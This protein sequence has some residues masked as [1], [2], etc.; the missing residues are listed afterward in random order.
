LTTE[1]SETIVFRLR[2]DST[3]G[4]ILATAATVTV[5]DSSQAP[6]PTYSVSPS[7]G[8][9]NE[10][11]NVIYTVTTTNFGYGTLY[12]TNSGTTSSADF[13][14][15]QNSGSVNISNNIGYITRTLSSDALTEGSESII[16]D[17]RT[18]S[19]S[20]TIVATAGT[21]TV[22]DTSLSVAVSLSPL[23][24]AAIDAGA[25]S[26]VNFTATG[27]TGPYSYNVSSG[28]L[29]SGTT[30]LNNGALQ[31][32][33]TTAGTYSFTVTA[34]DSGSPVHTGAR[35]YSWVINPVYNEIL[36]GP[37]SC[38]LSANISYTITGG[39][40]NDAWSYSVN[41]GSIYNV[42]TPLS[43]TGQTTFSDRYFPNPGTYVITVFFNGT[44]HTRT[45]TT[46]AANPTI[47]ISP[48]SDSGTS[49]TPY[50][51]QFTASGGQGPYTWALASGSLPAGVSYNPIT[52]L[53][54]GTPTTPG[55]YNFQMTAIDAGDPSV[56]GTQAVTIVIA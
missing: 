49:G 34:T 51:L 21:V 39:K 9:V 12:W 4:T 23:T 44:S 43:D 38:R 10:G 15:G 22:N 31:G 32:S 29:P 40:P 42:P 35:P 50:S 26:A 8:S 1:G 27:G 13:T 53:I 56:S 55:T 18:S 7:S 47:T 17:I 6:A 30:L 28:T 25:T 48:G 37:S 54:A 46:V 41:G 19:T 16:I 3:A 11:G 24:I 20:G 36:T 45:I 52:G 5:N 33:P 14:D 2:R